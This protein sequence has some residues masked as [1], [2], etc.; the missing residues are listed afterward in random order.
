MKVAQGTQSCLFGARF[1]LPPNSTLGD[2]DTE[3]RRVQ[4]LVHRMATREPT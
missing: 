3:L 2:I 1:G 4:A